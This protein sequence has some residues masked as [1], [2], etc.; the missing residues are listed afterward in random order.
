MPI[1]LFSARRFKE[2]RIWSVGMSSIAVVMLLMTFSQSNS[3]A[4]N[5]FPIVNSNQGSGISNNEVPRKVDQAVRDRVVEPQ[6]GIATDRAPQLVQ[7]EPYVKS[8]R[9]DEKEETKRKF[10]QLVRRARLAKLND[11]KELSA[12][13]VVEA[14]TLLFGSVEAKS[15]K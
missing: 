11:N 8:E 10:I 2:P 3:I 13:L 15:F 4:T 9:V 14:Q 5:S 1:S 6:G 7:A 12:S